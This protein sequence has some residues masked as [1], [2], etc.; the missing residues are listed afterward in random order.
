[1]ARLGALPR[2]RRR[3]KYEVEDFYVD[4]EIDEEGRYG[5]DIEEGFL[6]LVAGVKRIRVNGQA[7]IGDYQHYIDRG[8]I[9]QIRFKE[10]RPDIEKE[11]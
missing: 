2:V 3:K 11:E 7:T 9:F 10:A 8:Y 5:A 6:Y 1:M 4:V